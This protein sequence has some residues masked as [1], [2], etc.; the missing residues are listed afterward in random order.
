MESVMEQDLME[1]EMVRAQVTGIWT[2][3]ETDRV[4][5]NKHLNM[6]RGE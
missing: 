1:Q 5:K 6:I 3:L 2:A 4:L